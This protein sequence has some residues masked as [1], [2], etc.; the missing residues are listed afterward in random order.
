MVRSVI[1]SFVHHLILL[2]KS[3]ASHQIVNEILDNNYTH[4]HNIVIKQG[5]S[6]AIAYFDIVKKLMRYIERYQADAEEKKFEDRRTIAGLKEKIEKYKQV[7]LGR[8]MEQLITAT[9]EP[10]ED[11]ENVLKGAEQT[12]LVKSQQLTA[13]ENIARMQ[14]TPLMATEERQA[15]QQVEQE[16]PIN[17]ER[18][19]MKSTTLNMISNVNAVYEQ[20]I[21]E[22][23]A[24]VFDFIC[25]ENDNKGI[26]D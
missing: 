17:F 11:P 14:E 25:I 8:N 16:S 22:L 7:S 20:T 23:T 18:R 19:S 10:P 6:M 3:T 1:R 9:S 4:H 24:T 12:D 13:F 21:L 5:S 2:M 15:E 26:I